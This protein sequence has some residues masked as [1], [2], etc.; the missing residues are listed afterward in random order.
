[1]DKITMQALTEQLNLPNPI[2]PISF[3]FRVAPS[4]EGPHAAHWDDKPAQ[5]L[6][7]AAR[8]IERLTAQRD[9]SFGRALDAACEYMEHQY[10][11]GAL[12]HRVDRERVRAIF[13]RMLSESEV[14]QN[15]WSEEIPAGRVEEVPVQ[16]G[17]AV[18]AISVKAHGMMN[19]M[20]AAA[21]QSDQWDE[22]LRGRKMSS[23]E[24]RVIFKYQ[25]PVQERFTMKLPKGAQIIR[26]ADQGG[27]FWL[28]AVVDTRLPDVER[29]FVAVKCGANVPE[30]RVLAYNG[31]CAIFVQQE[32]GLYIFEDV[33]PPEI[34][35]AMVRELRERTGAGMMD[36]KR[37]LRE[38]AAD[39]EAAVEWLR[40]K[41]T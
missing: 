30:D 5:V 27:M 36:A 8:D 16:E 41:G 37:A 11:N 28:W 4:G 40:V 21:K 10:G 31:F 6:Y 1:M 25:M 17:H 14:L 23:S 38:S 26:V 18:D 2:T 20:K 34:T 13:D 32:L 29:K 39:M 33:T 35:A 7:L 24:G 3:Q 22:N 12:G 19:T 9:E 15:V